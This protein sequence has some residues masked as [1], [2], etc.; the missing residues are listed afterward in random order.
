MSGSRGSFSL[1][2]EIL[3]PGERLKV[4]VRLRT[5][6]PYHL[7]EQGYRPRVEIDTFEF[8]TEGE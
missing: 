8:L 4:Q 2:S 3:P 5:P 6:L 1:A 7:Y